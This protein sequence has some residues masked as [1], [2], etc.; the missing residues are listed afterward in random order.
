MAPNI[1]QERDRLIGDLDQAHMVTSVFQIKG[2]GPTLNGR[3]GE[4]NPYHTDGEI[5][6]AKLVP[7]GERAAAPAKFE[8]PPALIQIK[9]KIF[10]W[11][12]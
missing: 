11:G 5:W 10:S 2:I 12:S 1:D 4:G 6:I 3:N 7:Q 8:P 9:D